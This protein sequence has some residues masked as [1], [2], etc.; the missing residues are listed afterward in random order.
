MFVLSVSATLSF[1]ALWIL[2][3]ALTG[4]QVAVAQVIPTPTQGAGIANSAG[5]TATP[6]QTSNVLPPGTLIL[7]QRNQ[8]IALLPS[9]VPLS[10]KPEQFG[11]QASSNGALGV[12]FDAANGAKNLTL[13][14]NS[15]GQTKAIPQGTGFTSPTVTWKK[16]GSGFAFF[17]FPPPDK[18]GANV[19]AILYFNV[20]SGATNILIKAPGSGQIATAIAWSPDGRYLIYDVSSAAAEGTGGPDTKVFLFDSTTN[21]SAP[22]P[23]DAA[24]FVFWDRSAQGFLT[25]RTDLT[26]NVSQLLHYALN[27]LSNPVA[28]TP[29]NTLDL[30]ADQSPDGTQLVVSSSPGGKNA[31]VANLYVQS[32]AGGNRQAITTFKA[33]DRT[34]TGLVWNADAIYYS[35]SSAPGTN[36]GDTTWKVD[37]NGQNARQVAVGTLITIVG[38]H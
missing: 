6:G 16:D 21:G 9:G 29:A 25:Q 13:V 17:D 4:S 7:E 23:A 33:S 1:V 20:Q 11:A 5:P 34:I 12:R 31:P 32:L 18:T 3:V 38:A 27:A 8:P 2:F 22:L 24:N 28:L 14:D 30:L 15:N 19:G 37:A 35:L 26:N 10:L 36:T